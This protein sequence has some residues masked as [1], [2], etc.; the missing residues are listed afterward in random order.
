MAQCVSV[1]GAVCECEYPSTVRARLSTVYIS[2][3]THN[4][5]LTH[6]MNE[7]VRQTDCVTD[8][9]T[10]RHIDRSTTD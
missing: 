7:F 8:K 3:H 4:H 9:Q 6:T 2:L 10:N 5:I 1:N